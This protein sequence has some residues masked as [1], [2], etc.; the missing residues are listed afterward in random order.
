M[1]LYVKGKSK[2]QVNRDLKEGRSIT[3]ENFSFFG[4]AGIYNLDSKL[5]TGTVISIFEKYSGGCP[6]A[7]SY[8]TWD[9]IKKQLK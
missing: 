4:G 1:K 9:S 8:G 5:E 6:V 2:A 7:K 3:G